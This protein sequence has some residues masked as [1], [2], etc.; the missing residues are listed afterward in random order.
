[1]R[2]ALLLFLMLP[3]SACAPVAMTE[4]A[5]LVSDKAIYTAEATY[6]AAATGYLHAVDSGLLVGEK[7][8]A[9]KARILQAAEL[10][11]AIKV[12][13]SA[14]TLALFNEVISHVS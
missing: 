12:T 5:A 1:M 8:E 13:R 7:K 2:A 3:A 11:E 10:L 9:Y 14:S 4:Q 6:N